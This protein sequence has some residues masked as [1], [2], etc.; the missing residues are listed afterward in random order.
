[1]YTLRSLRVKLHC[2]VD[3]KGIHIY[4][5][6]L[7]ELKDWNDLR[8]NA[9]DRLALEYLLIKA[10]AYDIVIDARFYG[11]SIDEVK[12]RAKELERYM[13]YIPY[14]RKNE[15]CEKCWHHYAML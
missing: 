4:P 15:H 7:F 2:V 6:P 8:R 10:L 13:E 5:Y 1:M 11:I 14:P 3:G 12:K 9:L